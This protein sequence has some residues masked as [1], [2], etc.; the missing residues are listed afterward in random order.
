MV[1]KERLYGVVNY[2]TWVADRLT[3]N[4]DLLAQSEFIRERYYGLQKLRLNKIR[5]TFDGLAGKFA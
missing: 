4:V 5:N 1:K 2:I 3:D